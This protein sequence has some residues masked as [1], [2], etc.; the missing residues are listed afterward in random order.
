MHSAYSR[1]TSQLYQVKNSKWLKFR[2]TADRISIMPLV[3]EV[4]LERGMFASP[5]LYFN[6]PRDFEHY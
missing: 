5:P 2:K 6:H 1:I 4:I 3:I